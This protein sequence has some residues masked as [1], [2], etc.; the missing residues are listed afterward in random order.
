MGI[1]S[2]DRVCA[3]RVES[4]ID[5]AGD[6]RTAGST[7]WYEADVGELARIMRQV[8][9]NR[10]DAA[11]VGERAAAHVRSTLTWQHSAAKV[12]EQIDNVRMNS[13]LGLGTDLRP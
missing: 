13:A 4:G 5:Q 3:E 7:W 11:L 9:E 8:Y 10:E 1:L 6:L 12:L 2:N